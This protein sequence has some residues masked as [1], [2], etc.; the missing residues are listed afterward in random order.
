MTVDRY[1]YVLGVILLAVAG[2]CSPWWWTGF[3]VCG[4]GCVWAF[5]DVIDVQEDEHGDT[6]RAARP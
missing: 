2:F 3:A 6:P 4:V 1:V 5:Y